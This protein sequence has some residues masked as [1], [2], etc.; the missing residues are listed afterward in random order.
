MFVLLGDLTDQKEDV[1]ISATDP[2]D[3]LSHGDERFLGGGGIVDLDDPG[4]PGNEIAPPR[5]SPPPYSEEEPV[6]IEDIKYSLPVLNAAPPRLSCP[7]VIPQRRPGSKGRGFMR[8]YAPV[9]SDYDMSEEFFLAFLKTFHKASM[10][11]NALLS[12]CYSAGT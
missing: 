10:V 4:Q 1:D 3:N 9:L 8:A 12:V 5:Y 11:S 7:V 6:N 2:K